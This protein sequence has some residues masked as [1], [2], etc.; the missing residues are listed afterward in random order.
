[1]W[2]FEVSDNG[3]GFD[4]AEAE[5]VFLPFRRLHAK[6]VSGS[7]MGLA[8]CRKIVEG[9]GGRMG[10]EPVAGEGCTFWFTLREPDR[11]EG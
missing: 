4:P 7:G 2:R 1:M 11:S 8:V 9:H 3:Q 10:V 5:A 6:D